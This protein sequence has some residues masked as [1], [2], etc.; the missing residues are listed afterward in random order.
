MP[1]QSIDKQVAKNISPIK[2][3]QEKNI[4]YPARLALTSARLAKTALSAEALSLPQGLPEPEGS[5]DYELRRLRD[6]YIY[7]LTLNIGENNEASYTSDDYQLYLY[8]YSSPE[9]TRDNEDIPYSFRQLFYSKSL[10]EKPTKAHPPMILVAKQYIELPKSASTIDILYSDMLLSP[11]LLSTLMKDDSSR[12][13]WMR[14]V[15][16]SQGSGVTSLDNLEQYV[17]DFS[18]DALPIN[19]DISNLYRF[20]PIG[21]TGKPI[22]LHSESG[23]GFIVPVEDSIGTARDLAYYHH[24]LMQ[25]RQDKLRK[26]EYAIMTAEFI[27]SH[28]LSEHWKDKYHYDASLTDGSAAW[29]SKRQDDTLQSYYRKLSIHK[30]HL[31]AN[32]DQEIFN[33]IAKDLELNPNEIKGMNAIHKMA[34]IPSLYGLPFK[35]LANVMVKH[36]NSD[37]ILQR[38]A[39]LR[40][41]LLTQSSE[42]SASNWCLF[43]HGLLFGLDFT[44][45]G[46]NAILASLTTQEDKFNFPPSEQIDHNLNGL[47]KD[48]FDNLE[49]I[50]S[51]LET[52][53]KANTFDISA[54]DL[55]VD[56]MI[57]KV[58][59]KDYRG[60]RGKLALSEQ[61]RRVYQV[62]PYTQE[63]HLKDNGKH[64]ENKVKSP[65][66]MKKISERFKLVKDKNN[67]PS[68]TQNPITTSIFQESAGTYAG[69]TKLLAFA[70]IFDFFS[71][72]KSKTL[73]G[74]LANDPTLSLMLILA[75]EAANTESGLE[76]YSKQLTKRIY[77][78]VENLPNKEIIMLDPAKTPDKFDRYFTRF[79]ASLMSVNT[80]FASIG[81]LVEYGNWK[82]AN[83]KGDN[84]SGYGAMLRGI[85]GLTVE[86]AFGALGILAGK[87][88]AL[89]SRLTLLARL[90]IYI[91]LAMIFVGII[92]STLKK[93][94]IEL[95]I[96][97]GYWG[98]SEFYWGNAV[99][100][101]SWLSDTRQKSFRIQ[102]EK[103]QF[104]ESSHLEKIIYYYEIEMQRYFQFKEDIILSKVTSRNILVK[105]PVIM[106]NELAQSIKVEKLQIN[107]YWMYEKQPSQIE[108]IEPG[109][110]ILHFNTPWQELTLINVED[111]IYLTINEDQVHTIAIKVSMSDYQGSESRFSSTLQ[112]INMR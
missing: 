112:E 93:E 97:N 92:F 69:L 51:V 5:P 30:S 4:I 47:L 74:R 8:K 89:I 48:H 25:L 66:N 10:N 46:R 70:P 20:F 52:L 50:L 101:F 57:D 42:K 38:L 9:F 12:K 84:F 79:R 68:I 49:K 26:Y 2:Q 109:K 88:T 94:D 56:I 13:I 81:A 65:K 18:N 14:R 95:W 80:L 53:A 17:K 11:E 16:L 100:E 59:I 102:F 44:S 77:S 110:A 72:D 82:E 29:Y 45:Y 3:C 32:S 37:N 19:K 21:K 61:I 91:G 24:H 98:D 22:H 103:S 104:I 58:Y 87:Q 43:M 27:H 67:L 1:K 31:S 23:K 7:I 106:N 83:Y 6:G 39:M 75:Q 64:G 76:R 63:I 35:N 41:I 107:G 105:H 96:K 90:N 34:M 78:A 55:F 36:L 99:G 28:V 40:H 85:G 15:N 108:Y 60:K 111:P 33:V 54:Y 86:T 62:N 71:E 73:E